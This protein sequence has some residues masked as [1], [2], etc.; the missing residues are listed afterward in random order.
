MG[1]DYIEG[2]SGRDTLAGGMGN[3]TLTGGRENDSFV[4]NSPDEGVD[5]ITDFSVRD[6]ALVFSAAGFGGDLVGGEVSSE[7]LALGAAA[8]TEAHRFIYDGGSG[9]LFYDSDGIGMNE[10]VKLAQLSSG[11][12]LGSDN[13]LF[14]IQ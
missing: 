6:D 8:T 1:N 14:S 5:V 12:S 3:D 2:D 9:E 4:F 11:L 13:L 10:K 7:M